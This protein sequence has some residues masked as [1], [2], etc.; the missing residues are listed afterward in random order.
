MG[1]I[2]QI[3]NNQDT[4]ICIAMAHIKG[5]FRAKK[6]SE[7]TVSKIPDIT[8]RKTRGTGK[9]MQKIK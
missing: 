4:P 2:Y 9:A 1:D 8:A 5:L 6:H 3:L 7:T